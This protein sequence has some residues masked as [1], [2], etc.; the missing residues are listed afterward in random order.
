LGLRPADTVKGLAGKYGAT[1][2][3]RALSEFPDLK[4]A[5]VTALR[6]NLSVMAK[7]SVAP[8]PLH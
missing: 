7:E 8:A 5:N 4:V 1:A 6:R 3:E 2:V